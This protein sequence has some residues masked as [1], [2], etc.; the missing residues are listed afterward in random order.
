MARGAHQLFR[1]CSLALFLPSCSRASKYT[2]DR[3]AASSYDRTNTPLTHSHRSTTASPSPAPTGV[4]YT[5]QRSEHHLQLRGI[6]SSKAN[7]PRCYPESQVERGRLF[8]CCCP[9]QPVDMRLQ[10][11]HLR[12]CCSGMSNVQWRGPSPPLRPH[13]QGKNKKWMGSGV[14]FIGPRFCG[15]LVS[16]HFC[17]RTQLPFS[18]P[19]SSSPSQSTSRTRG[20]DDHRSTSL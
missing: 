6:S 3:T 19:A 4:R 14:R 11:P 13:W 2:L 1:S 5:R 10:N 8:V 12:G 9:G 17:R 7:P 18:L 15:L 16:A 20:T